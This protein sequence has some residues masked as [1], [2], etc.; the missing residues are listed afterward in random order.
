MIIA[1]SLLGS[2]IEHELTYDF[3]LVKYKT[4]H[5]ASLLS[6][7]VNKSNEQTL[8]SSGFIRIALILVMASLLFQVYVLI[9]MILNQ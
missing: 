3:D 7:S 5:R 2:T 4:D 6:G 1:N 9:V 8:N